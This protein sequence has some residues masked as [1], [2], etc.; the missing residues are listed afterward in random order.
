MPRLDSSELGIGI[1]IVGGEQGTSRGH[2]GSVVDH[3]RDCG[4]RGYSDGG[5]LAGDGSSPRVQG[6]LVER[7]AAGPDQR[8]IPACAGDAW[9]IATKRMRR[10]DHP[11]VCGGRGLRLRNTRC[12]SGSS[13]R[14][15]GTRQLQQQL[16]PPV[17][18]IPACAGDA[19]SP[20]MLGEFKADHP[21]VCGGRNAPGSRLLVARGSSP[22][23]R[24]TRCAAPGRPPR[25]RI[26]PACAGTP[27]VPVQSVEQPRII[28]ACAGD[29]PRR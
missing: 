1:V 21:R 22:R 16:L 23:V 14:V 7:A 5:E 13:P 4:G 25:H 28:P 11:R 8:I 12:R 15:R 9:P 10:P 27:I 18:I 26:I 2:G 20:T 24:G 3:T 6:T 17:R 29:A 19:L